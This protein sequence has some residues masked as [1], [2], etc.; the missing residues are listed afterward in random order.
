MASAIHDLLPKLKKDGK[1]VF[2]GDGINDSPV[3]AESDFGISIGEGTEIANNTADGILIS[4]K[5]GSIPSII[6]IAKK[7]MKIIKFN[8]AFSLILKAI[9]L[10]LGILGY[11]PVWLAVAVDT[12]VTLL[13]VL[14]SMRIFRK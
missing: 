6:K 3:L 14:N 5:I 7:S 11:A 2:V 1:V 9:V 4:N 13:T 12:G 8:I 10:T